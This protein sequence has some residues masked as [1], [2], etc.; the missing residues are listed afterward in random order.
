MIRYHL[1]LSHTGFQVKPKVWQK[2]LV[3]ETIGSN[4]NTLVTSA[5]EFE[6]KYLL[7]LPSPGNDDT[8][9]LVQLRIL[10]TSSGETPHY[11]PGKAP[12][13]YL[14]SATRAYATAIA[15]APK[16]GHI[17]LALGIVLEELFYAEDL[18][19]LSQEE[20]FE[21]DEGEAQSSSK[22]EEFLAICKL[23]GVPPS[24]PVALQLKAVE[25]EYQ[26][27]K[28]SGQTHKADHVQSLY[29]WKSKK[30]LEVLSP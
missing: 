2:R 27:L 1:T 28:E 4:A 12:L 11:A 10:I 8:A 29:A 23:Q 17:H 14:L 13:D 6:K 20:P 3:D 24:A 16:E 21:E 25:V 19:G 26:D 5:S 22:E 18:Y 7:S 9:H 30:V 15:N